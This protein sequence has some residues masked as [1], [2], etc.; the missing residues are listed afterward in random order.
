MKSQ[1]LVILLLLLI[2]ALQ[3]IFLWREF[4]GRP[5]PETTE[6][7]TEK[8]LPIE[9]VNQSLLSPSST[10]VILSD[11]IDTPTAKNYIDYYD[12]FFKMRRA[13]PG[14][15][16]NLLES[17]HGKFGRD[18]D[19]RVSY[20]IDRAHVEDIL[21]Q[22][23]V[24]VLVIY[25][26]RRP[27]NSYTFVVAGGVKSGTGASGSLRIVNAR[28]NPRPSDGYNGPNMVYDE[29]GTCPANCPSVQ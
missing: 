5:S 22:P 3:C 9:S 26:A 20:N 15:G 11:V 2:L 24:N 10:E 25:P 19:A 23:G 7:S 17:I 1:R 4:A 8:L 13:I 18:N 6:A 28:T 14:L 21:A 27:N 16:A 29:L 12:D